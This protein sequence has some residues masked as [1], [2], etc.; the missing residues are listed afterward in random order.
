MNFKNGKRT[1]ATL[2]SI[3]AIFTISAIYFN[4]K[5]IRTV[6]K[7]S[8]STKKIKEVKTNLELESSLDDKL[9]N[10]INNTDSTNNNLITI[11]N[12]EAL[13]KAQDQGMIKDFPENRLDVLEDYRNF[14]EGIAVD[15]IDMKE[16]FKTLD[17]TSYDSMRAMMEDIK[18][19]AIGSGGSWTE[20][21]TDTNL[22]AG[23]TITITVT[24]MDGGGYIATVTYTDPET[25]EVLNTKTVV[26][27]D[28]DHEK[29][30][31]KLS[32][33]KRWWFLV[34]NDPD[35]D[36]DGDGVKNSEDNYPDD[37]N[38]SITAETDR[39]LVFMEN[40]NYSQQEILDLVIN[41]TFNLMK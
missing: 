4:A 16:F 11:G 29:A 6:K 7:I 21:F 33:F 5:K 36:A 1:W 19:M 28:G 39:H 18:S 13:L 12:L 38:K 22:D 35:G 32:G 25:G 37:P 3:I 10:T 30:D 41:S 34:K 24:S 27:K 17:M 8:K 9:L 15:K 14:S 2:V 23:M 40:N 20:S 31:G 26:D